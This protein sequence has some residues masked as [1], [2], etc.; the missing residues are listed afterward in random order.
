MGTARFH[1]S[2]MGLKHF[3]KLRFQ[4]LAAFFSPPD[5]DANPLPG[6]CVRHANRPFAQ[7]LPVIPFPQVVLT[8]GAMFRLVRIS[9]LSDTPSFGIKPL[10]VQFQLIPMPCH[11][12][13][14][15]QKKARFRSRNSP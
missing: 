9:H 4:L 7:L 13:R 14:S 1:P 15:S 8:P 2:S 12:T 5:N 10:N 6:N 3:Q 11:V